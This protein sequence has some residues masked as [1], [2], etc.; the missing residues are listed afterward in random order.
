MLLVPEFFVGTLFWALFVLQIDVK[1]IYLYLELNAIVHRTETGVTIFK[2][3]DFIQ[4]FV[5]LFMNHRLDQGACEQDLFA[6]KRAMTIIIN[7]YKGMYGL[8][9]TVDKNSKK[10]MVLLQ[11]TLRRMHNEKLHRDEMKT[12]DDEILVS[13]Q[14]ALD[15]ARADPSRADEVAS[16]ED[17]IRQYKENFCCL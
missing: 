7:Y 2:L 3:S 15:E 11:K 10:R 1:D 5:T 6:L 16:I 4:R 8:N 17:A 14:V 9:E 12:V 13:Y